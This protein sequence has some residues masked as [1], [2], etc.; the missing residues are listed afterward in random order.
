M[1]NVQLLT[2][3][4]FSKA[5][6]PEEAITLPHTWNAL[7]GQDG[8]NDYYRG[9]C[10]YRIPLPDPTKGK[11]Q[12]VEFRGANHV[13][14][15]WCNGRLLGTHEGGFSTFRFDLTEDMKPQE[16]VLTVAV[17]NAVSHVYPQKAD[18]TFFGGIYRKVFFVE[19]EE[20]HFDLLKR[21]TDALFVTPSVSGL[22][23][24]DAFPVNAEGCEIRFVLSD[25]EGN[26]LVEKTVPAEAHSF[27]NL[28]LSEPHLWNGMED[29]YQYR[30]T[31]TLL[32]DGAALDEVSTLYGYRSYHADPQKGF[33]LN[34]KQLPLRGVCRH[35]DRENMGWAISEKEHEEDL[36][37]ICE[38]GANTIRLAH[39]QHDRYFYDL[40][41]RKGLVLW[42]EIPY[43]SQ[44]MAGKAAYENTLSQMR[45][46]IAQNYNHPSILFWG[47]GN[48]ITIGGE[49][50]EQ[51]RNLRDLNALCKT[52]DPSRPTTMAQLARLEITSPHNQIT[53]LVSY[54]IYYGWYTGIIEDNEKN[55]D[56]FHKTYPDKAFGISEYGVDNLITWHSA[57][58]F[59]HD[60]TEEYACLYH[61]HML[62]IFAER[63]FLWATH[64]WNMFDFAVDQRNE[65]GIK[66]RNCK[67]LITYDRKIKKD[68]FFLYQ[69]FWTKKPMVHV[70]GRRFTD[71]APE[72]RCVSVFTNAD[73][74]TLSVNGKEFATLPAIDHVAKFE[75]VPLQDG[76]NTLTAS[77]GCAE[78]TI[79]LNAVKE[80]NTAYDLPDIAEALTAGNWFLQGD[81]NDTDY[82]ENGYHIGI[83]IKELAQN[84]DC[85]RVVRGWVMSNAKITMG[86]KLHV[87]SRL[88]LWQNSPVGLKKPTELNV[89]KKYCISEDLAEL[90]RRLRRIRR[91]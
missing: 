37:L 81:D 17:S 29:P 15:V 89:V 55:I 10:T 77:I 8:G 69:A 79:I 18:F 67:G 52:M 47:I 51:Y 45:E 2:K 50:E 70:A 35:Q 39:Y 80:H 32:R 36:D 85:A 12:Y 54:N 38:V 68:I 63:P 43:I 41:D 4:F 91:I 71:R 78:D 72:E 42:A 64:M 9:V 21:G 13:A 28:T 49:C 6:E 5:G 59:S 3:A 61:H 30:A 24:L 26:S 46:L 20:A 57:E 25:A 75:N 48:E 44:H 56:L 86:E 66:G 73:Q 76:A 27:V 62:K 16:N 33:F 23:R 58:P 87:I 82:G 74:V 88:P 90:D 83:S 65:G 14:T 34:G 84:E 19:A 22:T 53:D 11:K 60:Y 31:A 40:C 1:R 7:D